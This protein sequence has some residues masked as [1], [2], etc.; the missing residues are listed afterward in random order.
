LIC[1]IIAAFSGYILSRSISNV[2][3]LQPQPQPQA[4]ATELEFQ[5]K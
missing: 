2:H 3:F 5:K 1:F 4:T